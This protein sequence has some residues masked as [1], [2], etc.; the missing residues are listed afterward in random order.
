MVMITSH[1]KEHTKWSRNLTVVL[2]ISLS[3]SSPSPLS[4]NMRIPNTAELFALFV[5]TAQ[6]T[7]LQS[8]RKIDII[9]FLLPVCGLT[10]VGVH[11]V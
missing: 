11:F 1:I 4:T 2:T 5:S 6:L 3:S 9:P 7:G 10:H 8:M